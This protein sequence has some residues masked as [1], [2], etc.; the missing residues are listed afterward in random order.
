MLCASKFFVVNDL[1]LLRISKIINVNSYILFAAC[2][3]AFGG[4]ICTAA[5]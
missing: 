5:G 3:L 4:D 1:I 2:P